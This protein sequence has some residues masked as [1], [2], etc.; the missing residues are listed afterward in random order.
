MNELDRKF[1]I[2]DSIVAGKARREFIE[3]N[4]IARYDFEKRKAREGGV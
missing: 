4:E 2:V 3:V 1:H